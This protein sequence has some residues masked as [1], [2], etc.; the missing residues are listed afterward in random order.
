MIT[1]SGNRA[2][3]EL[4]KHP[5]RIGQ[6]FN[7]I[8]PT[9]DLLNHILSAGIDVKW[10]KMTVRYLSLKPGDLVLD[11][12]CGTGDLGFAALEATPRCR[13]VGVDLAEKM[14]RIARKKAVKR[15]PG[16]SKYAFLAADI[17]KL[18][19][20]ANTFDKAMV[21]FGIRNVLDPGKAFDE[22][23]RVLKPGG[24]LA[25]LEFSLPEKAFLR[26][27]YLIYFK[28][29]LPF[30]GG[31]V[32][33]DPEAYRYLPTSVNSFTPPAVL[34]LEMKNSGFKIR[35][36]KSFTGGISYLILGDKRER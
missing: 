34:S 18:P 6:M 29:I 7:R 27:L 30:V 13:V 12:A 16:A 22:I 5:S 36:I 28:K 11:L 26:D 35:T 9:Y 19:F 25:I 3:M 33:G 32:S 4:D 14:L 1:G 23:H 20:R 17:L 8:A 21:A 2:S 24:S 15:Q 10:R 31:L